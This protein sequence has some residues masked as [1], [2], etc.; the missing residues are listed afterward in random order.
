MNA[1]TTDRRLGPRPDVQLALAGAVIATRDIA[2]QVLGALDRLE[3]PGQGIAIRGLSLAT[4]RKK[5]S[6]F[7]REHPARKFLI[8]ELADGRIGIRRQK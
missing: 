8:A 6:A 2:E 5:A 4:V 7:E 3:R 1:V